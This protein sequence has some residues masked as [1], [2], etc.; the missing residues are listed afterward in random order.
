MGEG[1]S[2]GTAASRA[3]HEISG[4]LAAYALDAFRQGGADLETLLAGVGVSAED[5]GDSRRTIGWDSFVRLMRNGTHGWTDEEW[6]ELGRGFAEHSAGHMIRAAARLFFDP[7]ETCQFLVPS[8]PDRF[9]SCLHHVTEDL[10][11]GR[12]R[13]DSRLD[14]A[15]QPFPEQFL[16]ARGALEALPRLFGLPDADVG[17]ESTGHRARFDVAFPR[18]RNPL[19]WLR[20]VATWPLRAQASR[21]DLGAAFAELRNR[22]LDLQEQIDANRRSEEERSRLVAAIEKSSDGIAVIGPGQKIVY[23]NSAFAE[24][25]A[26]SPSEIVGEPASVLAQGTGDEGLLDEIAQTVG[27]GRAWKGRYQS[28]WRDGSEHVRDAS[29]TPML[30]EGSD[31]VFLV[32][33]VHDVTREAELDQSLRSASVSSRWDAWPEVWPTTSTTS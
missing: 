19:A 23:A 32:A 26:M 6:V 3:G 1:S 33:V 21:R 5:L 14:P 20:R 13:I 8:G 16:L 2:R 4:G 7:A 22:Q 17:F 24:M 27:R 15:F 12:V 29:I 9:M 28:T 10:G 25:M 30:V 18:W 31:D 11:R